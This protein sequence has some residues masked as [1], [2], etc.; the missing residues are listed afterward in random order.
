MSSLSSVGVQLT[1][2]GAVALA[3]A[4]STGGTLQ[5]TK[6]AL[7]D[8]PTPLGV[9]AD[10]V[11]DYTELKNKRVESNI[12]TTTDLGDGLRAI[13]STLPN[14]QSFDVKEVG[15]YAG[16]ILFAVILADYNKTLS[17]KPA[18]EYPIVLHVKFDSSY[19]TSVVVQSTG[20]FGIPTATIS[21]AGIIKVGTVDD[22]NSSQDNIAM[23]AYAL[24]KITRTGNLAKA[25][26]PVIREVLL[27]IELDVPR[28]QAPMFTQY[29]DACLSTYQQGDGVFFNGK[30]YIRNST[31]N[32][33]VIKPTLTGFE[34][35]WDVYDLQQIKV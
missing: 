14:S 17:T 3:D 28:H 27:D 24:S 6:V 18:G 10:Y 4:I 13:T 34:L 31:V 25:L 23:T 22:V 12:T 29:K 35:Y 1:R 32:N 7:G 9:T 26:A 15:L 2:A 33:T 11:R 20:G 5:L 8:Y 21:S 16:N 19:N 30:L